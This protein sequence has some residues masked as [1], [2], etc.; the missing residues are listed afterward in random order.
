MYVTLPEYLENIERCM[1][2][3]QKIDIRIVDEVTGRRWL[4][5]SERQSIWDRMAAVIFICNAQHCSAGLNAQ[6][7]MPQ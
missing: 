7:P 4:L 3:A 6:C 1:A 5:T 2:L